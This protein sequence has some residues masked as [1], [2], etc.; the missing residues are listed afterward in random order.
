LEKRAIAKALSGS[1]ARCPQAAKLNSELTV[2]DSLSVMLHGLLIVNSS[3]E[4]EA[5]NGKL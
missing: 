2:L 5:A 1:S 4:E 3:S